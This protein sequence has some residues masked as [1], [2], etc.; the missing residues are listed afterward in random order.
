M[1]DQNYI[2]Y[3]IK[4]AVV[5]V[6]VYILISNV[7]IEEIMIL[8]VNGTEKSC[9]VLIVYLMDGNYGWLLFVTLNMVQGF[10]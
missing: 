4:A 6:N 3:A 7:V 10:K 1:A 5:Q 2:K 8:S 9:L